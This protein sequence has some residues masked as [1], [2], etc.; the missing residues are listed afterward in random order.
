MTFDS[1]PC[2]IGW[3]TL[4]SL[5]PAMPGQFESLCW[6]PANGG[7]WCEHGQVAGDLNV[8]LG[9]KKT[10]HHSFSLFPHPFFL[11]CVCARVL[12]AGL[13]SQHQTSTSQSLWAGERRRCQ[14][15]QHQKV[16]PMPLLI[17]SHLLI[18]KKRRRR[19]KKLGGPF[20]KMVLMV[21]SDISGQQSS[22]DNFIH[23]KTFMWKRWRRLPGHSVKIVTQNKHHNFFYG[24]VCELLSNKY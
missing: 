2:H 11:L 1:V 21:M 12:P 22:E 10:T 7:F 3:V 6:T 16:S 15:V 24:K 20:M 17:Y 4:H 8:M 5:P 9:E 13:K 14:D 18:R 23:E 19:S